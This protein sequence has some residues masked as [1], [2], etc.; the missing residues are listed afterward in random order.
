LRVGLEAKGSG[1]GLS[2]SLFACAEQRGIDI[3]YATRAEALNEDDDRITGVRARV[4]RSQRFF[5]A[6]AVVLAA[7]GF[8]A[9]PEWRA[10]YLGPGWDLVKVRGSRF[11]TGDGLA[12]AL[13]VGA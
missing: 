10:R 12:M 5:A 9:S 7:G 4:G 13:R 2:D 6:D 3:Q 8:Q 11:D 1:A